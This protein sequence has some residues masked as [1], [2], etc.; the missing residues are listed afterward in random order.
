MEPGEFEALVARAPGSTQAAIDLLQAM[1]TNK[2]R[3]PELVL[4]HGGRLLT[5]CPRKLGPEV[6]TVWEQVFFAAVE[7]GHTGWRDES[8]KRLT[9]QFPSSSRVERLK[10]LNEESRGDY[11]EA[12]KIYKKILEDKPEDMATHKRL[13]AMHKQRGNHAAAIEA[14]NAYLD[15][16]ST[17]SDVWHELAELYVE[18]SSLQRAAFCFEELMLSNPR[19]MYHILTYAELLYSTGDYELSRK[20]FSLAAY[21]DGAC[22]RALWGLVA[23]NMALAEKD[24]TNEKIGQLQGFAIDRLKSTYKG[25][26]AHGRPAIAL[27]TSG[28]VATA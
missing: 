19:S 24:K 22:L 11:D 4:L 5:T 15:T 1:R 6:W 2:I 25:I 12:T 7:F 14:I 13:I 27:L 28:L 16:F 20:Y 8:L 9:R 10:G 21:I 23:V 26:G 17:D 3:Q 18:N